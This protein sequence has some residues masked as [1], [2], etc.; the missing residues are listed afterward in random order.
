M[1]LLY[2]I[3]PP[4]ED[5]KLM[6]WMHMIQDP[7]LITYTIDDNGKIHKDWVNQDLAYK[8]ALFILS[9][10]LQQVSHAFIKAFTPSFEHLAEVFDKF[11]KSFYQSGLHDILPDEYPLG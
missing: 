1:R 6:A 7:Y 9:Q 11:G 4:L 3:Q 10:N 2:R 8:R 5:V